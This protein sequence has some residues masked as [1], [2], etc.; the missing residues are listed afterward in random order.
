[1]EDI[2]ILKFIENKEKELSTYKETD[3]EIARNLCS[4]KNKKIIEFNEIYAIENVLNRL[5]QLEKESESK[6]KAYTD[7]YCEFKHYKQFES[8]PKSVIRDKLE[9][10]EKYE[11]L[12]K[13]Q[14]E[15]RIVIADSDSLNYGRAEAHSKDIQIL[16]EIL[17]D[18]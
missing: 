5:E 9:K 15:N 17:G 14:I 18:E 3:K 10:L 13:E 12:A 16:K 11:K 7:C 2:E 6:E 8:I 4:D 1:M